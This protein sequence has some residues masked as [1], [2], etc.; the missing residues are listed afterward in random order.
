MVGLGRTTVF[1]FFFFFFLLLLLFVKHA[2]STP[3]SNVS[4]SLRDLER[5]NDAYRMLLRNLVIP[6]RNNRWRKLPNDIKKNPFYFW[7]IEGELERVTIFWSAAASYLQVVITLTAATAAGEAIG[8]KNT[9]LER[10]QI[11]TLPSLPLSLCK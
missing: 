2:I 7:K 11:A 10:A 1:F 3:H 4:R 5:K 8:A 9:H 6:V